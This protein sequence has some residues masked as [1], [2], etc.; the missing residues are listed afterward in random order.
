M[1]ENK[2]CQHCSK[3]L[4]SKRVATTNHVKDMSA[5][6]Y[7]EDLASSSF[8]FELCDVCARLYMDTTAI[9]MRN[10]ALDL[11]KDGQYRQLLQNPGND[12]SRFQTSEDGEYID[13]EAE[14]V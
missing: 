12:L 4:A 7:G 1:T 13:V 14:A 10:Y 11:T 5:G 8:K 6:T 9:Q 3:R 2:P